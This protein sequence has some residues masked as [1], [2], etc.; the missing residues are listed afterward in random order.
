[1]PQAAARSPKPLHIFKPGRWT[2]VAG[3]T[4]EFTEAEV[5]AMAAAYS[6][7]KHKAPIVVGHPALDA[8][9]RG[10]VESLSADERGLF[11]VP[12]KVDPAFAEEARAGRWGTVSARFYRPDSPANPVPGVWYLRHIG[13]LGAQPPGVKGLLEPEFAE[14]EG[15][16]GCV[17][18]AEGVAFG[19]WD[20]MT[21]ATLWR[22]LR[23]WV[24]S[25]FGLDE[26]DKVLPNHDV[27]SLELGA[28]E[29][30]ARAAAESTAPTAFAEGAHIPDPESPPK[31]PTVTEAEAA[32][33]KAQN[34]ALQ[35]QLK[36]HRQREAAAAAAARTAEHV[37]F[38]ESL[39][40]AGKV[41]EAD[42]DRIVAMA[43][44][45]HPAGAE[46]MF[47]EGEAKT[48]LYAQFKQFLDGLQPKV[49]FGEHATRGRAADAA[50]GDTVEYAENADPERIELDK[51]IR[52]HMAQHNVGYAAAARAV[53]K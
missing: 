44:V 26:A 22:Q 11:A 51:K 29:D 2:T 32:A 50:A 12:T 7:A 20:A 33:L 49:E 24:V 39:I 10:W 30:L 19:E 27:R 17:S 13:V 45:I 41:P 5:R 3:E 46:V 16:D 34:E 8:P 53:A 37:A 42:K 28:Q 47:G 6:P 25:K 43:D 4:I 40:S 52:A 31:E 35:T 18:F 14:G 9:A 23:D 48:T 36:E 21:N 1:M 38:A 15:E